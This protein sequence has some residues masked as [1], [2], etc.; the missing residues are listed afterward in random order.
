MIHHYVMFTLNKSEN[1]QKTITELSEKLLSLKGEIKE[2]HQIDIKKNIIDS[3][4]HA[5]FLL[6][7]V[8]KNLD[9]LRIYRD[10]PS[11][12]NVVNKLKEACSNSKVIDFET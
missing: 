10:H 2:L 9:D 11:H 7:T 1:K 5:D 4:R 12:Q 3:E 8:F 6:I